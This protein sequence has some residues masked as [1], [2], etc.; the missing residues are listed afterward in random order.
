[1]GYYVYGHGS[2]SIKKDDIPRAYKAMCELNSRDDLK[3]GG[4]Y[5]GLNGADDPRPEGLNYHPGKW[6]SWM[7]ANYPD[8]CADFDAIL[9]QLGFDFSVEDQ[10]ETSR[11]LMNY[12]NKIGQE[13]EFF[14]VIAPFITAGEVEWRGEDGNQWKWVFGTGTLRWFDGEITYTE[15]KS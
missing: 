13:D 2:F 11:Y 1:M 12:D 3:R 7:D 8:T 6:F 14:T 5:G 15:A 9:K 10:G 4:R